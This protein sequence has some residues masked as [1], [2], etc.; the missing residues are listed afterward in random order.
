MLRFWIVYGVCGRDKQILYYYYYSYNYSRTKRNELRQQNIL[1]VYGKVQSQR[2]YCLL[3]CCVQ[4]KRDSVVS[5]V[6]KDY[7]GL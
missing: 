4:A 1:L 2:E 3:P 7:V 5:N 6:W